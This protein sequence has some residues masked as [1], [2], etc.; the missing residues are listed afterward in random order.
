M[1]L[2]RLIRTSIEIQSIPSPTFQEQE[3][4]DFMSSRFRA[5]KLPLVEKD[6]IGN[7]YAR[8]GGKGLPPVI[9]SAHLDTVFPLDTP[10]GHKVSHGR[11]T[12]P[13][14]GDNAIALAALLELAVDLK[15][16][17]LPGEVWLVAN[18]GEEGMGNLSGIKHV[19]RRFGPGVS[20]YIVIEGMALGYI[21]HRGVPVR[22]FLVQVNTEGGHAWIHSGRIS[23][24][25][26]LCRIGSAVSQI[27]LPESPKT[28]LNIGR[29]AGG[30]SVNSIADEAWFEIDLRSESED[31]INLVEEALRTTCGGFSHPGCEVVIQQ[32]G[33]RPSGGIP[34][35]HPLVQTAKEAL[36]QAGIGEHILESGSTDANF[37]LSL[38]YP[39]VCVGI[40]NGGGAHSRDEYIELSLI[41]TGYGALRHLI[42]QAFNLGEAQ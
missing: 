14:I 34:A 33:E 16:G 6:E 10:L 22:R 37:P 30:T 2:D 28:I 27:P 40:T 31:T 41:P 17:E 38:G 1:D 23:A 19:V 12:G 13:G 21:Y 4:G 39:C 8:L 7:V 42:E 5:L 9:V 24:V 35:D 26:T 29:I 20:A 32:I 18:V 36:T 11:I 3:K 25:H 15:D